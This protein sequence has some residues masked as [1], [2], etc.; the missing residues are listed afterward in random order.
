MAVRNC[1]CGNDVKP[2]IGRGI[3]DAL[4]SKGVGI[5]CS[6]RCKTYVHMVTGNTFISNA[7][8]RTYYMISCQCDE[9]DCS[10]MSVICLVSC[11]KCGVQSVGKTSQTFIKIG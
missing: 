9:L 11:A 1:D 2:A 7:S 8:G 4:Q 6:N 5:C 10:S 3:P